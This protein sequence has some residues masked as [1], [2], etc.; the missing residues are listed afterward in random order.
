[1]HSPLI[2]LGVWLTL[3]FKEEG[4]P[5]FPRKTY[6]KFFLNLM[7]A[8]GPGKNWGIE[9]WVFTLIGRRRLVVGARSF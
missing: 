9:G 5:T 1:M 2:N 3:G 6:H 4:S 7:V 8:G